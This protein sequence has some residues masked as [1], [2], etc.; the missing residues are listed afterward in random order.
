MKI[1]VAI[2]TYNGEKYLT[3][4]LDSI[5]QQTVNPAEIV[6]CDDG[7]KDKT[8]EILHRY[9]EQ[10][11]DIFKIYS[12][13]TNLG[14]FKNFEKS[15][16]L[17]SQDIIV[18]SDQDDIWKPE[19]LEKTFNFF[20][21][22]PDKDAVFNDLVLVDNDQAILEPS[23]LK[24]KHIQYQD[25]IDS[26]KNEELF[27]KVQMQGSF[28]LGCALAIRKTALKEYH[29]KNFTYAHDYEIAQ[30]LSF[31]NKIGFIPET[32]SFYRQHEAQVCG[33]REQKMKPQKS[34]MMSPEKKNFKEIVWPYLSSLQTAKKLFPQEDIKKTDL[35]T[36]FL[37]HR[38]LYLKK[39]NF[40]SRKKY[41]LQCVKHQYLD[42]KF[43]DIFRY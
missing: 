42:L 21:N 41:I 1:S 22:N 36:K 3:E 9:Q 28:I 8:L 17:C 7:S 14:Y 33:L 6:V 29:L 18:T 26:I 34:D 39:L 5:L 27:I 38:N 4:Q 35:Y 2:C 32:L 30:K 37:K 13:E 23:Y 19:K 24:W 31:K 12:N 40:L 15:I 43:T 25:I 16:Y 20:K 10:Y 11:P